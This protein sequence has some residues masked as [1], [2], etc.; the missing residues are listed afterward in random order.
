MK[1]SLSNGFSLLSL[2]H[3]LT[4]KKMLL[5]ALSHTFNGMPASWPITS[6][7]YSSVCG[8]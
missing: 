3:V 8:L 2:W 4:L 1:N 6:Y 5:E 7:L